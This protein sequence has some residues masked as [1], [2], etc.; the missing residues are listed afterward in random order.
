VEELY[1]FR[2]GDCVVDT[3]LHLFYC[4][5]V[6]TVCFPVICYWNVPESIF[7]IFT[8]LYNFNAIVNDYAFI[9]AE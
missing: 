9:V 2:H 5:V 3:V 6:S 4:Y 1:C 8:S 7:C